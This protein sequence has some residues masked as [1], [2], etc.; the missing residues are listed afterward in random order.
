MKCK[1]EQCIAGNVCYSYP[2]RHLSVVQRVIPQSIL[3]LARMK[4][5]GKKKR[6]GWKVIV[7]ALNEVYATL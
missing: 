7:W 2:S 5:F 4:K 6:I 3:T 1:E